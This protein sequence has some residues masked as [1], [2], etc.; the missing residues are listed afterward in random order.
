M[1]LRCTHMRHGRKG[2]ER[3]IDIAFNA[4]DRTK[5]SSNQSSTVSYLLR[6]RSESKDTTPRG[7]VR[8]YQ[9]GIDTA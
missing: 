9:Y 7:K 8:L 5:E 2:D 4:C 1:V 6:F 3:V